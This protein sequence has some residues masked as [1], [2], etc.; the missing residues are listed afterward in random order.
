MICGDVPMGAS[1]AAAAAA[2]RLIVILNDVSY[3]NLIPGELAKGFGFLQGKGQTAF[4][5]VAVTP[6]ELGPH[7][8]ARSSR[9]RCSRGSTARRSAGPMRVPT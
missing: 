6:D 1:V 4:S 3:R 7:G 5:P 9:C 2:I 8:T